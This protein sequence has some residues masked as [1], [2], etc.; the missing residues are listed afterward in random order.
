MLNLS[1]QLQYFHA[2]KIGLK[3]VEGRP[4]SLKFKDIAPG[5]KIS[6]TCVSTHEIIYC[7][8]IAVTGYSNFY[9]MLDQQGLQNMLPGVNDI[10]QGVAV[11]ENFPGYREK[12]KKYGAIAIEI[13]LIA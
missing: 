1:L 7:T 9:E 12:V 4:N 10:Q 8:V 6:F 5:D 3:I 2:I 11:Y 13:K